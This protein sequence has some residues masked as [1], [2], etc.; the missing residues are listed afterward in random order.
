MPP[1]DHETI[2]S[3]LSW[4][5]AMLAVSEQSPTGWD[6][7]Y[8]ED[9]IR[10]IVLREKPHWVF[11]QEIPQHVPY[12]EGYELIRE[13]TDSHSGSI[14]S[15]VRQD[16]ADEEPMEH[17]AIPNC[18]VLS[19]IPR[20][21]LTLANVHLPP[22]KS[23]VANRSRA[24]QRILEATTT[25][26]LVVVGDTNTRVDEESSFAKLGFHIQRPPSATWNT[27]VNRFRSN[28]RRY[29]AYYTRYFAKGQVAVEDVKV[30][31]VPMSV[32][33]RQFF[34][35]DHFALSGRIRVAEDE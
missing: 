22:G 9:V 5:L 11:Y 14:V 24:I 2:Y 21:E 16:L 26:Q 28:D 23:G 33:G 6:A 34:L 4:N 1:A 20:L 13:Q 30:H 18:A 10:R 19:T 7:E 15:L 17:T 12:A 31:D 3:F 8:T 32:D 35:S 29:T 25:D 27:K